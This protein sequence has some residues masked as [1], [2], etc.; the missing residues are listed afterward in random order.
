M[1]VALA[2][3]PMLVALLGVVID[4]RTHQGYTTWLSAC[5]AAG[6]SIRSVLVFTFELLPT[7]VMGMLTGVLLVQLAG[8]WFRHHTWGVPS[9]LAAHGGCVFGMVGGLLLCTLAL[10]LPLMLGAEGLLAAL[11]AAWLFPRISQRRSRTSVKPRTTA[12]ASAQ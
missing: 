11:A 7:A 6:P 9:A 3:L 12:L 1:P 5:R 10:P 2:L 4:E 8:M